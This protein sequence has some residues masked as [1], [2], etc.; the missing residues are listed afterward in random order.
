M[1][2]PV[3]TPGSVLI[4]ADSEDCVQV[5]VLD[6]FDLDGIQCAAVWVEGSE[7]VFFMAVDEDREQGE[8]RLSSL[9]PGMTEGLAASWFQRPFRWDS[10]LQ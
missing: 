2:E 8:V 10:P 5:H 9:P 3:I 6:C 1:P 7:A 4:L